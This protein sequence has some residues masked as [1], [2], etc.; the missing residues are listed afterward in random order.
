MG[1]DIDVARSIA[2][3]LSLEVIFV[4]TSWPSLSEDLDR[5]RFDIA[6]GGITETV[7]RKTRFAV[8][9]PVLSNGK[10]AITQCAQANKFQ[11]LQ[12]IDRSNVR[13]IVIPG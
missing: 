2:K 13:V 6:M 1:F 3:T 10:I 8:S 4:P 9:S 7:E 12:D 11:S 5:G